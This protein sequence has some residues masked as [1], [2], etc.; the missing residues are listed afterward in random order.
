MPDDSELIACPFCEGRAKMHR[1]EI[2]KQLNDPELPQQVMERLFKFSNH[3][4]Q[5]QEPELVGAVKGE[6]RGNFYAEV[7][8]WN[9]HDVWHR[10]PKE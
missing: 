2:V 9:N 1:S 6:K 4:G 10:S 8:S 7:G 3:N 5:E